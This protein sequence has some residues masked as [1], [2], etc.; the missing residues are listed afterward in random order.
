MLSHPNFVVSVQVQQALAASHVPFTHAD[1]RR[2][3][4]GGSTINPMVI[5]CHHCRGCRG[6][7]NGAAGTLQ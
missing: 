2:E 5:G 1:G 6:R 4:K 7:S 3:G